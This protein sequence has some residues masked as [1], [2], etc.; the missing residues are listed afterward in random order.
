MHKIREFM[1]IIQC[2]YSLL[3]ENS[4]EKYP[5]CILYTNS[6]WKK[7]GFLEKKFEKFYEYPLAYLCRV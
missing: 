2:I 3:V 5:A 7:S 6:Y 1:N 4:V